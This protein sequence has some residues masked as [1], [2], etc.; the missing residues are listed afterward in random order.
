MRPSCR[1]C[2][3]CSD[4]DRSDQ[5]DPNFPEYLMCHC[6]EVASI[7]RMVF[8]LAIVIK[9]LRVIQCRIQSGVM[10]IRLIEGFDV[11]HVEGLRSFEGIEAVMTIIQGADHFVIGHHG[12]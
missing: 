11:G 2:S 9:I 8:L 5:S 1:S 12:I 3:R 7:R 10:N 4:L 6:F